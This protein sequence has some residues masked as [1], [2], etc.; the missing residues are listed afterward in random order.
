MTTQ[1]IKG[2]ELKELSPET[3][4]MFAELEVVST[5]DG[6]AIV[7]RDSKEYDLIKKYLSEQNFD[8]SDVQWSC[9]KR[10]D[11]HLTWE[12]SYCYDQK[13]FQDNI[14][15]WCDRDDHYEYDFENFGD[16]FA[17]IDRYGDIVFSP[18][19]I[20]NGIYYFNEDVYSYKFGINFFNEDFFRNGKEEDDNE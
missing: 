20:S 5:T 1:K 15:S 16:D 3:F 13:E 18:E 9:L 19:D 8:C 14:L 4:A 6:Y 11:G 12:A 17:I 7:A 10:R 2:F